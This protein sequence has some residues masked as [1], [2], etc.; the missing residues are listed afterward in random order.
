MSKL[1]VKAMFIH[2]FF[3]LSAGFE[4]RLRSKSS[5]RHWD[6]RRTVYVSGFGWSGYPWKAVV[7]GKNKPKEKQSSR[8]RRE[9]QEAS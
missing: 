4:S 8:T 2:S 9:N 5:A 7:E 1:K 3:F 6:A